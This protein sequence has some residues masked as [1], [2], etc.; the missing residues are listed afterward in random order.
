MIQFSHATHR[1]SVD[2]ADLARYPSLDAAI[3][4]ALDVQAARH[5]DRLKREAVTPAPAVANLPPGKGPMKRCPLCAKLFRGPEGMAK[6]DMILFRPAIDCEHGHV[7]DLKAGRTSLD[8]LSALRSR[9]M[10]ETAH[11]FLLDELTRE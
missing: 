3:R 2:S 7:E 4:I 1:Y 10:E 11:A 9:T 6:A 5:L 8:E